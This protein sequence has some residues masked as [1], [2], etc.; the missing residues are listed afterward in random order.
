M[1]LCIDFK[2]NNFGLL[3]CVMVD[4]LINDILVFLKMARC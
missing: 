1:K 2:V 3:R 4:V